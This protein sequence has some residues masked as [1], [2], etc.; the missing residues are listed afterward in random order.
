MSLSAQLAVL[1]GLTAGAGATILLAQLLPAHPHLGDALTRLNTQQR[2]PAPPTPAGLQDRLGESLHRRTDLIPF[3]RIPT[4][5]LALLRIRTDH[6]LG[7]RALL[8]L[9]GLIFPTLL[10]LILTLAGIDLPVAIPA[11]AGPLLA[12][13]LWMLP[14]LTI[15]TRAAAAREEFARAVAAY[16]EIV[17]LE[18][19]GGSGTTQALES[20]ATV[21]DSWAIVRIR[22]ELMRSRLGGTPPWQ[23]LDR[24]SEE[25]GVPELRDLADIMRLAGEEGAQVYEALRARGKSLRTQLLTS[26]HARAN[27]SS[28]T[29]LI[30]TAASA[31]V[32]LIIIAAPALYRVLY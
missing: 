2:P 6:W 9:V 31:I 1:G 10:G 8:A 22:E 25:L 12:I 11:I 4:R 18:R 23:G 27:A 32:F 20:A 28:D 24:L 3:L 7:E 21:A 15:K 30:P 17:A 14:E 26:E 19:L 29:M 13:G 16:I 5:D